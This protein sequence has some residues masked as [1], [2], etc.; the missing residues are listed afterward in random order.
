[1]VEMHRQAVAA[2]E[3]TEDHLQ[4]RNKY[5]MHSMLHS[6]E[7]EAQEAQ[8][9]QEDQDNQQEELVHHRSQSQQ[10]QTSKQWEQSQINS[11]EID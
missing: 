9:D 3:A 6:D 8:E 11:T 5:T 10:H 1:M 2:Q 4:Q 7:Q